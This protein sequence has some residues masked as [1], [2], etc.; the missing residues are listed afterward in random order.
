MAFAR[1]GCWFLLLLPLAGCQL[2][3]RWFGQGAADAKKDDNSGSASAYRQDSIKAPDLFPIDLVSDGPRPKPGF[4]KDDVNPTP[5]PP[6][7]ERA[8]SHAPPLIP[9]APPATEAPGPRI[10]AP[11]AP[12]DPVVEALDCILRG[13]HKEA[14]AHLRKYDQTTQE[15]FLRLLPLMAQLHHKSFENLAPNE[16]AVL[17]EQVKSLLAS[18]RP[19]LEL[20]IDKMCF[21][22]WVREYGVYKPLP[23]GHVFQASNPARPGDLVQLYAELRNFACEPRDDHFETR[24]ASSVEIR[25]PRNPAAEKLWYFRFDTRK[26]LLQTRSQLTDYFG[27]YTFHVPHLPPGV[28]L[29]TLQITDETRPDA[30]RVARKTLEFRVSAAGR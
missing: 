13:K 11:L 28:Y 9:P 21:C 15:L 30:R 22:E 4:T 5:G 27:N 23:E 19:R 18:L 8:G 14:L 2:P 7:R 24:L 1:L 26:E 3:Q 29:L 10:E 17:N 25:D 6:D 12:R 16:V 20:E